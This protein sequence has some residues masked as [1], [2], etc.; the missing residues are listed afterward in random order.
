LAAFGKE[1][2]QLLLLGDEGVD[3]R[4]LGVEVVR[5]RPLRWT[6]GQP[7]MA[8]EGF[9]NANIRLGRPALLPKILI[10]DEI[11]EES[12]AVRSLGSKDHRVCNNTPLSVRLKDLSASGADCAED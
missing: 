8:C 5:D 6:A 12:R 2:G 11:P 10:I 3:A 1:V 4:R 7:H 9:W